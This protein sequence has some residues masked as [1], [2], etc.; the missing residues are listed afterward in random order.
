MCVCVCVR[1]A[2]KEAHDDNS[3]AP[4]SAS[5]S[6]RVNRVY[7]LHD[8]GDM[9]YNTWRINMLVLYSH[10]EKK[11]STRPSLS[12][13]NPLN[14]R[15]AIGPLWDCILISICSSTDCVPAKCHQIQCHTQLASPLTAQ[16]ETIVRIFRPQSSPACL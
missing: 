6:V 3:R 8:D 16:F 1:P 7:G 12:S 2:S 13:P 4:A 14:N 15:T 10:A 9:L 11:Y 5:G